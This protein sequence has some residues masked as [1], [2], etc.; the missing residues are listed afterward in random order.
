MRGP[1]GFTESMFTVLKLDDF[2]PKDHPLR[3][4]RMWLNERLSAWTMCSRGCTRLTRKEA[5]RASRR[6]SW[7]ELCCCRCCTQFVASACW[8]NRF[9][10]TCCSAGSSACRWTGLCG[11]TRRS[12]RT[13]TGYLNTTYWCCCLT[14]QSKPRASAGIFPANTLAS[15]AR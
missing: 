3:P 11:T 13:G 7:C 6:R 2:V 15:M 14:R 4:I 5:G 9:P 10:T 8:W 12:A 1:D